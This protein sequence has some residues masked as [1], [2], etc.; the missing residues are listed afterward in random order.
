MKRRITIA[1]YGTWAFLGA[2]LFIGALNYWGV[3]QIT[4]MSH[5]EIGLV[6]WLAVFVFCIV[7][8][9]HALLYIIR[10]QLWVRV[11]VGVAY[12]LLMYP[13]FLGVAYIGAC[14]NGCG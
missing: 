5:F 3:P 10:T 13:L 14:A 12:I 4:E 2:P 7:S 1:A 8:G 6:S 11:L 9:L